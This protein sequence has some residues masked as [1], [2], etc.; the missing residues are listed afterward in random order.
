MPIFDVLLD[1]WPSSDR[2]WTSELPFDSSW[3]D[4]SNEL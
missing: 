4:G 2:G 3:W 1:I